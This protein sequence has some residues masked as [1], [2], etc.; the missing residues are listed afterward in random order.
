MNTKNI[1]SLFCGCG[2][3]DKGFEN[4]GFNI[5]A[6]NDIWKTALDTYKNNFNHD[7]IEGDIVSDE[8]KKQILL[9]AKGK[10]IHCLIGG[11]PC[12]AYS[13]SGLRDPTDP[14]GKL[15]NEY[16]SLVKSLKPDYIVMENVKGILSV[17]QDRDD[18]TEIEQNKLKKIYESIDNLK[19]KIKADKDNKDNK[20]T[21]EKQVKKLKAEVKQYQEPVTNKIVKKLNTCRYRVEFKT[22]NAAN[23]GVPQKRERVIFI[24]TRYK[25]NTISHPL[26]THSNMNDNLKNWKTVKQAIGYLE[27]TPEN[28]EI[29][30]LF[31]NHSAE[32]IE[33]IKK[34]EY[35]K[36]LYKSYGDAFRKCHPDQPCCTVK[37][38]HGG[39]FLHYKN[40][41]CMSPRELAE[42]QSFPPDFIFKGS[43]SE[44]LKQ[45]GNAVPVGLGEAIGKHIMKLLT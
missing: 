16:I 32:M 37:E 26:E 35:N 42:L 45:I 7:V 13:I 36:S 29:N 4:S 17:Y 12:Q 31:S 3:L 6:A 28:K 38:N 33:K 18:L 14:R 41:R 8:T 2:G 25:K 20:K 30:H 23:F 40:P 10:K 11:P 39:V 43:K 27:E 5:I 9:K 1:V 34:V 21:Y 22:L 24:G 19:S 15:F 44:I